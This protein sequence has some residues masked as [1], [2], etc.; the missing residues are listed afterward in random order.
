MRLL[1]LFNE[2]E[3][4]ELLVAAGASV[5]AVGK[6][7]LLGISCICNVLA[8]I[9]AAK[10]WELDENDVVMTVFTDSAEMYLSRLAELTAERGPFTAIDAARTQTGSLERQS[11]RLL[12][13]A[14]LPGPQ[15][16][17]QPEVL[18][19]GRAAGEDVRR[20][21]GPVGPGVLARAVRGRGRPLRPAHRGVQRGGGPPVTPEPFP[22]RDGG[23]D[24]APDQERHPRHLREPVPGPRRAGRPPGGGPHRADRARRR[25]PRP[26]RPRD[27]RARQARTPRARERP[28][29][30]LLDARARPREGRAER[31]LPGGPREPLVASRPEALPRRR[32][33]EREGHPP[34][35][36]PEG[37]DDP[38]RPPREPGCRHGLPRED[39]EGREG[40]G[41]AFL[42]LLRGLRPRRRG[43]DGGGARGERR[44]RARVRD[45][46]RP[47]AARPR[48]PPRGLHPLRRDPRESVEHGARSRRRLPRPRRRGGVR[49]RVEPG[50]LREEPGRPAR[51][52]RHPRTGEHRGARRPLRRD[53]QG[54]PRCKR[55][56]GRPQPAVEPQQRRRHRRRPRPREAG[57][58]PSA[59]ART[60]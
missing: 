17:P 39:R 26:V 42:P 31:R 34:R 21:P 32:R 11:V 58:S 37:D 10:Y 23:P 47:A 2:P 13:G 14:D 29:A 25:D 1:R 33:G 8:A 16:D 56:L 41:A 52:A 4:R 22:F 57:R 20:D 30:L 44:L 54:P 38:R 24:A 55:R 43:R 46:E 59:S 51:R 9:K 60:R 48:R 36:H 15:G 45:G 5:D 49:R 3:G 35:R 7:D 40:V 27:R 28:H 50:A 19:V 12:Q 53:R 6:L 18:H